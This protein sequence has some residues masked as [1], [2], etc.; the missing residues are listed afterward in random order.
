MTRIPHLPGATPMT[1]AF[2]VTK[3]AAD[4]Y[5]KVG[6]KANQRGKFFLPEVLKS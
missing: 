1:I 6:T 2:P 3:P 4:L 5:V